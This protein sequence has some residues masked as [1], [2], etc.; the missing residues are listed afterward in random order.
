MIVDA[1]DLFL[2]R[3]PGLRKALEKRRK[4]SH[5]RQYSPYIKNFSDLT[6]EEPPSGGGAGLA[7]AGLAA[8]STLRHGPREPSLRSTDEDTNAQFGDLVANYIRGS[9]LTS[10]QKL[11]LQG[12]ILGLI[13]NKIK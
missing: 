7:I 4:Y 11:T 8:A 3:F 10:M 12:E 9:G 6:T 13:A 2:Q 1:A 5:R